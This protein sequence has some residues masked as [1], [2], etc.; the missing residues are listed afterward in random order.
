MLSRR[1]LIIGSAASATALLPAAKVL[2]ANTAPYANGRPAPSERSFRSETI[3][4]LIREVKGKIGDKKLAA[5][6]ENCFPNTLDTTVQLGTLEGREDTFIITGDINA[7]W[8]R[9]SCAQVWPYLPYVK[10]DKDLRR[11]FRGLIHRHATSIL[12]DP[13]AN[14]FMRDP[15]AKSNLE[16]SLKD[17]TEMKPGVAERKWEIDSLCYSVRLSYGYWKQTG[18]HS[19]FD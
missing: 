4:S 15:A 17:I 13:Y 18:D 19:V 11:L 16:W 9:D 8:L 7:M 10:Q 3:D 5:L 12:V 14:A 1:K 2:G 6:F